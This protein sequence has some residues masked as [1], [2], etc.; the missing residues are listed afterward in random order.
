M[1]ECCRWYFSLTE[2]DTSRCLAFRTNSWST[3]LAGSAKDTAALKNLSSVT[4]WL[5]AST[6][7]TATSTC[8]LAHKD[9]FSFKANS[10]TQSK[11]KIET[12]S[13]GRNERFRFKIYWRLGEIWDP[14]DRYWQKIYVVL[15]VSLNYSCSQIRVLVRIIWE[16]NKDSETL[17]SFCW[18]CIFS[19]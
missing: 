16:W 11:T 19:K 13:S 2:S 8:Q 4:T 3:C 15:N 10:R 9:S 5:T 14:K 6:T 1:K 17:T 12:E 7:S 18:S